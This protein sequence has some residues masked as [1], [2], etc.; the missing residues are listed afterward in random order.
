MLSKNT[1]LLSSKAVIDV[2]KFDLDG[3]VPGADSR[4]AV[5]VDVVGLGSCAVGLGSGAVVAVDAVAVGAVDVADC[6]GSD[7]V[8]ELD[9]CVD[10]GC[11]VGGSGWEVERWRDGEKL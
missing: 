9:D 4:N 10:G 7:L 6:A 1:N 5:V 2:S 8:V 3:G 11:S